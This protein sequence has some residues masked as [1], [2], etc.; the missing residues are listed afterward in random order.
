V[1]HHRI[2]VKL[3][4]IRCSVRR[5]I[6]KVRDTFK[7]FVLRIFNWP[8]YTEYTKPNNIQ[9]LFLCYSQSHMQTH[10]QILKLK[11]LLNFKTIFTSL[12][13][14]M[15]RLVIIRCSEI[16][17]EIAAPP[18]V[19]SNPKYTLVYA[20]MCC[21]AFYGDRW[22]FLLC[23]VQLFQQKF[24]STWWLAKTCDATEM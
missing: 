24:R 17:V 13:H 12:L 19:S 23:R 8:M 10:V 18:S 1:K 22:F 21:G 20:P 14:Y 2:E 11:F 4:A 15:F 3:W 9:W 5:H 6:H 7:A 16:A